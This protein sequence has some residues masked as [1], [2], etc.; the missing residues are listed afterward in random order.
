[1]EEITKNKSLKFKKLKFHHCF[2]PK[3]VENGKNKNFLP[4]ISF[5]QEPNRT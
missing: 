3:T 2:E 5:S 4:N 1:M